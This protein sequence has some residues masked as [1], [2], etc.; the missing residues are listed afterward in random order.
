MRQVPR[1]CCVRPSRPG[2]PPGSKGRQAQDEA[3]GH[4][5]CRRG[6]RPDPGQ[7]ARGS[8]GGPYDFMRRVLAGEAGGA[9]YGRRQT[10]VEP[11]F[12]QIKVNRRVGRFKRRGRAAAR[13]EWRLIR[14]LT[15][16]SSTT[17]TPWLRRWLDRDRKALVRYQIASILTA[18]APR[19]A[20]LCDS[21]YED[22]A[23]RVLATSTPNEAQIATGAS[24]QAARRTSA[25]W[26]RPRLPGLLTRAEIGSYRPGLGLC[27]SLRD[28][29]QPVVGQPRAT[30]S[31]QRSPASLVRGA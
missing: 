11:V 22:V 16:C 28:D 3:P 2:R 8:R 29:E 17:D 25:R 23:Q 5:R 7:A 31:G 9:L 19:L 15:T 1:H 4:A 13:S 24:G 26:T 21:L 18:R 20:G 10:M 30:S 6:R 14:R 12:A 27:D